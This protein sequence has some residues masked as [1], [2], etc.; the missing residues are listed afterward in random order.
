[1][2]AGENSPVF[3]FAAHHPDHR[4]DPLKQRA[5]YLTGID[6]VLNHCFRITA[7]L[8]RDLIS[9]LLSR[10][11]WIVHNLLKLLLLLWIDSKHRTASFSL[12]MA[13]GKAA[14]ESVNGPFSALYRFNG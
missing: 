7:D 5:A 6:Q 4:H 10:A 2:V 9:G 12:I 3:L 13:K 11:F 1:M 8:I 14:Y